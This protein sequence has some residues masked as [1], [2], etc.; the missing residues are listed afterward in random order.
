M[1]Q[2][3]KTA[4]L[5]A[6]RELV[7]ELAPWLADRLF[8]LQDWNQ[9]S[10]LNVQAGRV[11]RWHTPGLLL[12]GDAAHVMSPVFGVG[13]NYA[14]QDAI[15]AANTLG[16]RLRAGAVEQRHLAHVQR[17]REWPTRLMQWMQVYGEQESA[18]RS[19]SLR[20]RLEAWFLG[21]PPMLG[22]RARLIAFGGWSP[23]RVAPHPASGR[24]TYNA[25]RKATRSARSR[26]LS[27][28]LNRVL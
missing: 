27:P 20:R 28:I 18:A 5:Q 17:R 26:A 13:I 7:A 11:E 15:V 19:R 8:L 9:T 6:V 22:V 25:S 21:L 16:P 2:Q 10:L 24:R 3:L 1:Y 14:I 12:I 23:E 4:G